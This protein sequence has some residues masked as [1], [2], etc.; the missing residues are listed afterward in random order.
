MQRHLLR[1]N[2]FLSGEHSMKYDLIV[3]YSK[4]NSIPAP[5]TI[6]AQCADFGFRPFTLYASSAIH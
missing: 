2:D 4:I 5:N 1:W 6:K 3:A